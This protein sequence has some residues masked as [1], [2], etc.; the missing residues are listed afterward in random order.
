MKMTFRMLQHD[1]WTVST[2]MHCKLTGN[3]LEIN[4]SHGKSLK[5]WCVSG[6]PLPLDSE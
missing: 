6:E 4:L 3:G 5:K 2:D 1:H